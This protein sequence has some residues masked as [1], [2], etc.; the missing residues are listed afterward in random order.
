MLGRQNGAVVSENSGP[1]V[2]GSHPTSLL[3]GPSKFRVTVRS[4]LTGLLR[5]WRS[6]HVSGT[7]WCRVGSLLLFQSLLLVAIDMGSKSERGRD[8]CPWCW[9][10]HSGGRSADGGEEVGAVV[11][12]MRLRLQGDSRGE[13][14]ETESNTGIWALERPAEHRELSDRQGGSF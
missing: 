1:D 4:R 9:P 3:C 5:G 10:G 2:I 14:K 7:R 6:C 11:W 8:G 12:G 13:A